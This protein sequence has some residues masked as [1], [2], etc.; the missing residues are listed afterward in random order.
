[1]YSLVIFSCLL[2]AASALPYF[3]EHRPRIVGGQEIDIIHRAF[4]ISLLNGGFHYCGGSIVNANTIVTA[5]HCAQNAASRYSIRAGSNSRLSGG[6]VISVREV[7]NHPDYTSSGFDSDVAILKLSQD[8]D[9]GSNVQAIKLA[10]RDYAFE[11]GDYLHVSGWG[12]LSVSLYNIC[13][14][15]QKIYEFSIIV[16]R[17]FTN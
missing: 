16:R 7:I 14:S 15:Q 1:M 10:P 17:N 12:S 11:D 5:A 9:F 8:L 4:Q 13:F 3:K 6:Q 2:V